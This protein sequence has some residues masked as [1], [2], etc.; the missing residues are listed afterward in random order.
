MVLTKIDFAFLHYFPRDEYF[1]LLFLTK[2]NNW[3]QIISELQY[4]SFCTADAHKYVVINL[5]CIKKIHVHSYLYASIQKDRSGLQMSQNL[6]CLDFQASFS[7]RL[8]NCEYK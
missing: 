8:V 4:L 5:I 2:S 6:Q 7:V 3:L 1:T